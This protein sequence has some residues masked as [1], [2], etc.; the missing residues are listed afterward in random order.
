VFV[1]VYD[2]K[3]GQTRW[4]QLRGTACVEGSTADAC[5]VA[6]HFTPERLDLI[7]ESRGWGVRET[8][9]V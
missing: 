3:P 2:A 6:V 5:Q 7:D 9:E 8:L 4:L 1:I